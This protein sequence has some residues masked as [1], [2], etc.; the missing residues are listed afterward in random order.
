MRKLARATLK[1]VAE[2]SGV[3]EISVSRVMRNTPNISSTLRKKVEQAAA[4][5]NYTPNRVAGALAS[6]STQL[7]AVI[8][9]SMSNSVFPEVLDGIDAVLSKTAYRTVLG[10]SHY[11]EQ[12]EEEI[13]QDL[14]SWNPSGI[15]VTGFEHTARSLDM[16]SRF[17]NPVIEIMDAD[18]SPIDVS[19]GVSHQQAG[20]LMADHLVGQ[21]YR[22]IAYVG[23]EGE[24]PSRSIKRRESF[25]KRLSELAVPLSC[26]QIEASDSSVLLGKQTCSDL[27]RKYPDTDAIYFDNDDLVVGAYM[28][29]LQAGIDIPGQL[30]LAGFNGLPFMD[31]MPMKITTIR[32]PRLEMGVAAAELFLARMETEKQAPA[33]GSKVVMPL[34]F[35][36]GETS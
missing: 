9:P 23:A 7:L 8:V 1:D 21:G 3:S 24:R 26:M 16:L 25:R 18:G 36:L 19:I 29:C 35:I 12:R 6:K 34:Q 2:L 33:E 32:T 28:H 10:I 5:L 11:D 27:L 30:A 17:P 13:I 31:A 14:L 22:K 4:T 20:I 15:I